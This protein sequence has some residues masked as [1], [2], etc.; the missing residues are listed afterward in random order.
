LKYLLVASA[1]AATRSSTFVGFIFGARVNHHGDG[2][3]L[4]NN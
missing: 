3:N 1:F 2:K 4:A